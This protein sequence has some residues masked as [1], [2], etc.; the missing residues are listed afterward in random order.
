MVKGGEAASG[1]V[2]LDLLEGVVASFTSS[3]DMSAMV[4]VNGLG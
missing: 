1:H 3:L 4:R 2:A